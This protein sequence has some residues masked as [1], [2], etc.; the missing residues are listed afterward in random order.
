MISV[1]NIERFATKDGPGIRT[2]VFLKGCPL[3]CPWCA[4][5]ETWQKEPVLMHTENK[6]VHCRVCE[7]VCPMHAIHFEKQTFQMDRGQCDRCGQCVDNCLNNALSINGTYME[8]DAILKEVLKDLDYYQESGGGVTFSGGEPLFQ[9]EAAVALIKQAKESGL[10]V[11]IET[12]GV[13]EPSLFHQAEPYI[14]LF[15]FD[16]KHV[17]A[18]KL[19]EVTGAP[20]EMVRKNFEYLC[21]KRGRD[22]IARVPVIPGFNR[23]DLDEILSFIKPHPVQAVNL[24]PFHNLGKTKWHQLQKDYAYEAEPSISAK[25]LEQ[26]RDELV[27]IGG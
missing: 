21:E 11:A 23:G 26:Y 8:N 12:T 1:S 7:S 5:P 16:I 9:K 13:C 6:C 3:H 15:L 24:L 10:H 27:T 19:Y 25:D 18:A 17:N 22:V 14:D 4:N 2:T 20:F